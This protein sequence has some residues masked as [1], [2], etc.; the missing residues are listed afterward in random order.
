MTPDTARSTVPGLRAISITEALAD[1][2]QMICE[3]PDGSSSASVAADRR[4]CRFLDAKISPAI[5]TGSLD[6]VTFDDDFI[7]LSTPPQPS[8]P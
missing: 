3:T 2:H 7:L 4:S 8:Q 5:G 6:L 1:W